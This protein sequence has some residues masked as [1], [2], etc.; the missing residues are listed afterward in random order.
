MTI[1]EIQSSILDSL[2][3]QYTDTTTTEDTEND[4]ELMMDD[5]LNIFLT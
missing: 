2:T 1:N 3:S 4:S 5:F